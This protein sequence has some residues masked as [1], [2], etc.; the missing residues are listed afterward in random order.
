MATEC[1]LIPSHL[2]PHLELLG[3]RLA[4]PNTTNHCVLGR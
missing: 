1:F 3:A 2:W 4:L